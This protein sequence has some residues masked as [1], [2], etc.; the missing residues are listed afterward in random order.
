MEKHNFIQRPGGLGPMAERVKPIGT[1]ATEKPS[2]YANTAEAIEARRAI[3][4]DD[5]NRIYTQYRRD[6]GEYAREPI[7]P[8]QYGE[9]NIVESAELTG[10]AGYNH[11][12]SLKMPMRA[13]D[14]SKAQY[15]VDTQNTMTPDMRAKLQILTASPDQTFLNVPDQAYASYP[16]SYRTAGS[17]PMQ[18][19][20]NMPRVKK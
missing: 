10:L 14:M 16:Q 20:L 3:T 15:L 18:M 17:L 2:M 12:D 5:M 11:K 4:I 7:G 9:G 13:L 6:R 19:P 1:L 8:I